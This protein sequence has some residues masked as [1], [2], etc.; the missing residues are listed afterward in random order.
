M[1]KFISLIVLFLLLPFV[2]AWE[3]KICE[4]IEYQKSIEAITIQNSTV[5][6]ACS[7]RM[8][9]NSSGLI[10]IYYLGTIGAYKLD[11]TKLW[12]IDSGFVT[13]LVPWKEEILVGSMG[14]LLKLNSSGNYTGRFLTKYKLYDFTLD[15]DYAYLAT[16]DVFSGESKGIVYKVNLSTMEEV[17]RVNLTEM[18]SRV[19]VGE[20]IYVGTGYPS[21]FVGKEKFG[22]VYG[23]SKDGKLLWNVSLGEWVRDI[24][25]WN[26]KAVVGTGYG[27]SGHVYIIDSQG[28]VVG[29][30]TL[31]FV[32]DIL[33]SGNV[34]Y[35]AGNRN[36]VT[37]DLDKKEILWKVQ[38]PYRG[39]VLGLMDGRLL[40]GA[41]E[42]KEKNGTIYSVGSLYV[43][44]NGKIKGEMPVGY[45][46]SMGISQDYIAIGTGSNTFIVLHKDEVLPSICGVGFFLVAS[47]LSIVGLKKFYNT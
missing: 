24:E 4:N 18:A 3:G 25:V 31:F 41:G 19:R 26:G 9:A 15:G 23:I 20:V 17:W 38:I 39:K 16:G 11:G 32:E 36:V 30:L 35:V 42:F 22:S 14:G 43:I 44:E 21:G 27:E 6:A 12:E 29:N 8:V 7:Y 45:V 1:K 40:V 2:Q 37:I 46:R 10:G 47:L 5:Y 33:V 28:R 34:A 13:K